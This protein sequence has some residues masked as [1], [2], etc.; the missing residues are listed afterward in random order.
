MYIREQLLGETARVFVGEGFQR[1]GVAIPFPG[2]EPE[3]RDGLVCF[4]NSSS[5]LPVQ[6]ENFASFGLNRVQL[7]LA[8][9]SLSSAAQMLIAIY[10]GIAFNYVNIEQREVDLKNWQPIDY[11]GNSTVDS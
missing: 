6:L 11:D 2:F 8:K 1:N 7:I 3:F 4:A 5:I 9:K 10:S